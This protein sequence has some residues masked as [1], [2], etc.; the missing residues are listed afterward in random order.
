MR[1]EG[2]NKTWDSDLLANGRVFLTLKV[3]N[4][5]KM[6]PPTHVENF[7]SGGAVMRIFRFFG[8]CFRT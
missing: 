5:A 6:E 3:A 8:A 7:R 4:D 2:V 1:E